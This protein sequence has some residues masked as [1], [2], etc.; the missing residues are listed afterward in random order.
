MHQTKMKE[1]PLDGKCDKVVAPQLGRL[2]EI[3]TEPD[4]AQ[5]KILLY[6]LFCRAVFKYIF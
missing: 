5:V 6:F 2:D 3:K 1:S 4:N